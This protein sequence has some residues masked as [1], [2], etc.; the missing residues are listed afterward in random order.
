MSHL[1][2][3]PGPGQHPVYKRFI[4][5]SRIRSAKCVSAGRSGGAHLSAGISLIY[6]KKLNDLELARFL[7]AYSLGIPI[8]HRGDREWSWTS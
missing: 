7:N 8:P 6:K 4:G 3:D 5:F 2:R 1:R